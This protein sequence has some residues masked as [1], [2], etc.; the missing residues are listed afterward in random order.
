MTDIKEELSEE[1]TRLEVSKLLISAICMA[2]FNDKLSVE[3]IEKSC[4]E[5]AELLIS[6][7][8]STAKE[9]ARRATSPF[10][11]FGR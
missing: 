9:E 6:F 8:K 10:I 7:V 5:V 11:D 1:E 4:T 2:R 3:H